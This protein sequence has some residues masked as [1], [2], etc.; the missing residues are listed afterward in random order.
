MT[1]PEP[2]SRP[3]Q[4][5]SASSTSHAVPGPH[6]QPRGNS[7]SSTANDLANPD[8][9]EATLATLEAFRA[10]HGRPPR[11]LGIGNIANNAYMNAKI[12]NRHGWECDVLCYD[13]YH[14]MGCPEWEDADFTGDVG[15]QFHPAWH[16]VD[17]KGFQRPAWFVQGRRE[18]CINYLLAK[19]EGRDFQ[20]RCYALLLRCFQYPV[21]QRAGVWYDRF[22]RVTN[23]IYLKQHRVHYLIATKKWWIKQDVVI[24]AEKMRQGLVSKLSE[25]SSYR[26]KRRTIL[27]SALGK[28]WHSRAR[29]VAWRTF[30]RGMK[31]T[32]RALAEIAVLPL[33]L[34]LLPWY[35]AH[36]VWYALHKVIGLFSPPRG[37]PPAEEAALFTARRD[38]LVAAFA[39]LF[40]DREDKLQAIELEGYRSL[41]PQWRRLFS[42]YDLVVGYATDGVYPMLAGGVPFVAFEHGTIRHIP[43]EATIQGR[44]CALTFRLADASIITNCDNILAAEKLGLDNHRFC[45]HPINEDFVKD[46]EWETLRASLRGQLK[47]DFLVFHP[48]RQHWEAA[49]H[50]SWEK[51]NDIFIRGFARFVH[52]VNPKAGAVFV[53]WGKTIAETKALLAELGVADRVLWIEPQPTASMIRYMRACDACADQFYLGAFGGVMPKAMVYG[54]PSLIYLD[55]DRHRWCFRELPPIHNTRTSDAVADAFR[56]LYTDPQHQR[57]LR[58]AGLDW[59]ARFHSNEL[60]A[61]RFSAILRETHELDISK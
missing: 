46:P 39:R 7:T 27:T 54:R 2:T 15:D 3:A 14:I 45:P 41:M 38:E 43:F 37:L 49:R 8:S 4:I 1:L 24:W 61:G 17:L 53:N 29:T 47:S 11:V 44:L 34:I 21:G 30:N 5:V 13:Y 58:E 23:R 12:L 33:V 40:P 25:W 10:K 19:H 52:E 51:G 56:Q 48:S 50:P 31:L 59:Y 16:R 6:F 60:I 55:D 9:L 42:H 20:A 32:V 22:A 36:G 35:I 26:P 18:L 57:E 28:L